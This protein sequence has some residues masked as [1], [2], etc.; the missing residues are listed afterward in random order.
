M[1]QAVRKPSLPMTQGESHATAWLFFL[2]ATAGDGLNV[3]LG[4]ALLCL[5][6]GCTWLLRARI[7][8]EFSDFS[9]VALHD[10]LL[11]LLFLVPAMRVR[12]EA[13]LRTRLE[14]VLW[15]T[16]LF[17]GPLLATS[18]V[19]GRVSSL[20]QVVL[21]ALVPAFTV[22]L[23]SQM[24]EGSDGLQQML[25]AV[26]AVGALT[27]V[28]DFTFP[29]SSSGLVALLCL[30]VFCGLLAY[31]AIR[32][33]RLLS[34][35]RLIESVFLACAATSLVAYAGAILTHNATVGSLRAWSREGLWAIIVDLPL[36]LL[37]MWLLRT[38]PP[39][40]FASRNVLIPVVTILGGIFI[41]RPDVGVTAWFGIALATGAS[42]A[43]LARPELEPGS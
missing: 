9:Q 12:S 27:L 8:S 42:L 25:P 34:R 2:R 28:V 19:G 41:T 10:G 23:Q 16:I 43:L 7:P 35:V 39:S 24:D 36:M 20:S 11:A 26:V 33:H 31:A 15:S 38:M 22:F 37:S 1:V 17:A 14:C 40:G 3:R 13:T 18:L 21:F 30:G 4:F 29:S 5:I 32:L 6:S